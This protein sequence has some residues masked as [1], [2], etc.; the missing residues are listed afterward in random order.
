V[1]GHAKWKPTG[2]SGERQITAN[3]DASLSK[4]IF[5]TQYGPIPR[6]RPAH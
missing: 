5:F 6:Y 2:S 1:L 3:C 4:V